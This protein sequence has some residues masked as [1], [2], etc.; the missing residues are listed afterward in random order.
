MLLLDIRARH[1][2]YHLLRPV[3]FCGEFPAVTVRPAFATVRGVCTP[4]WHTDDRIPP[5][6]NQEL[7]LLLRDLVAFQDHT[8][9][10]PGKPASHP[11]PGRRALRAVVARQ[12][13]G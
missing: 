7:Q 3:Q 2:P 9:A 10:Q 12:R 1:H 8:R 4:K 6:T 11:S 13:C 5:G